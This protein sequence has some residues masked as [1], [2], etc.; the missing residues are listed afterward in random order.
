[1]V[2]RNTGETPVPRRA[3][4]FTDFDLEPRCL[5]VLDAMG[6]ETPTPIQEQAIPLALE[7]R[8]LIATAQTGTGKTLGFALPA[9]TRLAGGPSRKC[10]MLVLVPTRELAVQVHEVVKVVGKAL[11]LKTALLYGG[12]GFEPQT[13][14]LRAG[15]DIVVAT[16][17]RLL[18]HMGRGAMRFKDLEIL[19]LD[20]ADRMLDMGFLPDIQRILRQLPRD[21]QTMLFSATFPDELRR[22]AAE[23][24]RD[25]QRISV[26]AV[27]MPVESVRQ[28]LYPVRQEDK[29][30]LLIE[31]LRD[32]KVDSAIVFLRT[33]SRTHRLGLA[34]RKAGLKPAVIHGDLSQAQRQQA[35][36]GFRNGKYRILVATDVA[37]RGL[38]IEDVSHVINYDI[39]TNAD[40]YIHRIGRTARA[41]REGDAITFVCPNEHPELDNIERALGQNLPRYEYEGAPPVLST[42]QAPTARTPEQEEARGTKRRGAT[43]RRARGF[44]R[45]H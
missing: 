20:E 7:G 31:L 21:R 6:I 11:H 23:M 4:T 45:R 28:L 2:F 40:D 42:W 14:A 1:M 5:R 36:D 16:P 27:R 22:I 41:E 39:P 44:F 32:E 34:L 10:R 18:D 29:S 33:K 15:A 24:T 8:D 37:A 9:L 19:V 17:G 12:V 3:M 13:A 30:R 25:P 26:G 43:V 35:L 38:D